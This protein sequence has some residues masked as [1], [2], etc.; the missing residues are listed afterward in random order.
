MSDGDAEDSKNTFRILVSTDNHLGYAERDGIRGQDSLRTFEEILHLA[1]KQDVDLVFFAGDIFHES[2]PSMRILHESIRLLRAYCLGSKPARFEL[3]SDPA[4]VF[5][6]TAF[7]EA[8]YLDPNLNVS[9]PV[10]AIHGNHDD[11]SGPGGLC[12][13]DLLHSAGLVNLIGK[14][15]SVERIEIS[16]LLMRKGSTHLAIYGLG[17]M[18]EERVHRLFANNQVTFLRPTEET[19]HW[20]SMCAVHQNRVRHG[21]T[22]YLPENFLPDFLDL[23]V[24]GHEHECRIEA[25][26]NTMRNFYV[27]QPGSSVAT[28]LSEGEACQKAVAL[29]EIREKEF[30][31]TRLPLRTVRPLIFEDIALED[32]LPKTSANALD[33]AKQ[34]EATCIRLVES[35]IRRAVEKSTAKRYDNVDEDKNT[36]EDS[37]FTTPAEPLIRIRL[38]LTGGFEAFSM[39]RFGQRFIGRVANPKDL[40]TFNRNREQRAA[41]QVRRALKSGLD[42]QAEPDPVTLP[43][44]KKIGLDVGEME[45]LIRHYLGGSTKTG[46]D[47][48]MFVKNATGLDV[49]T[50]P[51]LGKGL[52]RFVDQDS[53]DAIQT[54]VDAVLMR[55]IKHLRVRQTAE[56]QIVPDIHSFSHSRRVHGDSAEEDDGEEEQGDDD[57]TRREKNQNQPGAILATK[58]NALTNSSS[59]ASSRK[60]PNPSDPNTDEVHWSSDDDHQSKASSESIRGTVR[61]TACVKR[62]KLSTGYADSEAESDLALSE[63]EDALAMAIESDASPPEKTATTTRGRGSTRSRTGRR[64][65]RA[66]VG[67]GTKI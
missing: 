34:V 46:S 33:L 5:S 66:R 27:I 39:L 32:E 49:F 21:P 67:R 35:C 58:V 40:I 53:R 17:A 54:I 56:E 52:R 16:P 43:D 37:H 48:T 28:A 62:S 55:T 3:L 13:A 22:S 30:K 38:D 61:R 26:W 23:V 20:F 24:W 65:G 45:H 19:D 51:E 25:E 7:P 63:E 18:R 29:L 8:N 31:V 64:P 36:E 10:F 6:N 11:P 47:S 14:T 9:I 60:R 57:K 1:Q 15:A 41:A 4:T 59:T 12:A 2:R 50:P 44:S 42:D